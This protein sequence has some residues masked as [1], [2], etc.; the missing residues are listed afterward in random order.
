MRPVGRGAGAPSAVLVGD[1]PD[2][3]RHGRVAVVG[4]VEV[5]QPE[6]AGR[7]S[8]SSERAEPALA[9]GEPGEHPVDPLAL[10]GPG[11]LVRDQHHDPLAV[12]VGG[13][14]ASPAL[15]APYLDD[16]LPRRRHQWA[17]QPRY[18]VTKES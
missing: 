15:T 2:A 12:A 6:G 1:P 4:E 18:P 9:G 13:H 3:G 10:L 5:D 11:E 16:R 7:A 14:R 17:A 8:S